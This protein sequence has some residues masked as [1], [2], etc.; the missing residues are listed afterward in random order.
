MHSRSEEGENRQE[1]S[2]EVAV[3][4]VGEHVKPLEHSNRI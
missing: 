2:Q 4:L 1:L 3:T